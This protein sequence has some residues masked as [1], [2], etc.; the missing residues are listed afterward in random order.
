MSAKLGQA[1]CEGSWLIVADDEVVGLCSY[2]QPPSHDG[3]V[4]IG[5]G[6]AKGRRGRGYALRAVSALLEQARRNGSVATVT[7]ATATANVVSQSVLERNG[8][9]RTGTTYDPDDG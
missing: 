7:A 5:Y 1:G 3:K 4:E 2:K 6:I 8:F 9:V